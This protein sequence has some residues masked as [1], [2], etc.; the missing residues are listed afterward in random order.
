VCAQQ[1]VHGRPVLFRRVQWCASPFFACLAGE[2][3]T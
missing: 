1:H 3:R 2:N